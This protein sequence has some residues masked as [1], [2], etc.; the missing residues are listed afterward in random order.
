MKTYGERDEWLEPDGLGGFASGTACGIRT[1]RYHALLLAATT[2][3][4]GRVVL[5]NGFDAWIDTAGGRFALTSQR[6]EPGI[7]H[8][9]GARRTSAFS[10][11]PWPRWVFTVEDG[12]VIEQ[13]IVVRHGSPLVAL[14]WRLVNDAG[15]SSPVHLSVRPFFS[16]RDY[17]SMHR[18]NGAF[19]FEPERRDDR[20]VWQPYDGIPGIHVVANGD[21]RHQPEWYRQFRYEEEAARGLDAAE[22]LAAPGVFSWQLDHGDASLVLA[23]DSAADS[24]LP[25]GRGASALVAD[26]HQSEFTRRKAF[27]SPLH[28]AADAYL[29]TRGTGKTIVA[30]YPWFTDWGRDT[31]IAL[32]GICLAAGRIDDGLQILVEWS[33][34]ISEGML[35]NR[36]PDRGEAP[37]FNSVDASLWFIIAVHDLFERAAADDVEITAT[38]RATLQDA[39]QAILTR[40]AAGT[41]FG[42][43]M[44]EDGLLAAGVP[45]V[46]LTWMDARVGD[47]VITPR[48]GKPVEVQALWLNALSLA[49]RW[50][51]QWGDLFTRG[52]TTFQRR[53]W[54]EATSG[55]NDVVDVDHRP[56]TVDSACRPNQIF[57]LGG[58]PVVLVNADQ[59]SRALAAVESRLWTPI[60]LRSLAANE[61]GY[62]GRYSGDV[63][64]RDGAY[65]QGTVWPW[66]LTPFVEAWVRARGGG[67]RVV[68]EARER[69]LA[70]L[71]GHLDEAGLGHVSEIAD[72]NF[73][74]TP[75]GCAFQAWSVGEA[76]RLDRIV[77]APSA[78]R[79]RNHR[80]NR[81]SKGVEDTRD[82][83]GAR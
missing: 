30:G 66:L 5:V 78:P 33:R 70:P 27:A 17:H 2:P 40:Y 25:L 13:T 69:F 23:A 63:P 32:R 10:A 49:S 73:P 36:F 42:I 47:H 48:I 74:H 12:T 16:G 15:R 34:A 11:E 28:R 14:N 19:R 18:Q 81:A 82:A 44:D 4:T 55:L 77:L 6:Y 56:G 37:E 79:S 41:R 57:A 24:V 1:R 51:P 3:P 20:L 9:D 53:F 43:R 72:G 60:G 75:N 61:P 38:E 67:P 35:P 21:Y 62:I 26:V 52:N 65:H 8:P 7:V 54:N 64:A 59:A 39:V 68:A 22:D 83:M 50:S 46:Q 31:F 29:V 76:L 80:P 58:L 71:L 45:G